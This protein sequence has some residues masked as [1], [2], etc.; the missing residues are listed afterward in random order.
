MEAVVAK[1]LTDDVGEP[2]EVLARNASTASEIARECAYAPV[3]GRRALRR[4][5]VKFETAAESKARADGSLKYTMLR[6]EDFE[7][8]SAFPPG[9]MYAI[10]RAHLELQRP[11]TEES[12]ES[13]GTDI[14]LVFEELPGWVYGD[15]NVSYR[16]EFTIT[17]Y[18]VF[19][20]PAIRSLNAIEYELSSGLAEKQALMGLTAAQFALGHFFTSVAFFLIESAIVVTL[21][22]T[23]ETQW[24]DVPYA[25][26]INP[27]MVLLSFFLYDVGQAL[28]PVL[29]TSV[30]PKGWVRTLLFL[31]ILVVAPSLFLGALYPVTVPDYLTASRRNQLFGGIFPHSA[32]VSVMMIM[33]LAQDY[34]DGAGWSLVTRRIMGNKVT[35]LEIW[36]LM[37]GSNVVMAFLTW[38]LPQILPWCTDNPRSPI[39]FLTM[40]YWRGAGETEADAT[41]LQRD[42]TRFEELP[43]DVRPIVLTRDLTK[44]IGTALVLDGVD[45]KVFEHKVTVLLGQNG[46]GKS[47]LMRILTGALG[48]PTSGGV[49][50]C[51]H[52]VYTSR[53]LVRRDVTLCEQSDVFFED[54]TC[55]ENAIYFAT[56]KDT[57]G[58]DVKQATVNM[59]EKL[60][61]KD[62]GPKMPGELASE[63]ARMLSLAIAI[64][65]KPKLLMLDEPCSDLTPNTRR[66]I[67]D[68]LQQIGR[69]RTVLLTSHDMDEAD[70]IADQIIMLAAGKVI[71]SGSTT[72]LKKACGV[73]YRVTLVKDPQLF[74]LKYALATIQSVVPSA[75]VYEDKQSAV[76]IRLRTLDHRGLPGLFEMLESSS[77]QLGVVDIGVTVATMKDVYTKINM[78]WTPEEKRPEAQEGDEVVGVLCRSASKPERTVARCFYALFIKRLTYVTRSWGIFIVSFL[79]PMVLPRLLLQ[80]GLWSKKSQ[81]EAHLFHLAETMEI[82]LAHY[83]PGYTV[84]L[85]ESKSMANL[86]RA[87]QVLVEAEGCN[88]RLV[89]DVNDMVV[90]DFAAYVRTYPMV[91]VPEPDRVRLMVDTRNW[92]PL[93]VLLNLAD[94]AMLRLLTRQPT[95]RIAAHISHLQ[96]VVTELPQLM[97]VPLHAFAYALAF[98]AFAAFPAAERLGGARDVQLMTGLTGSVYV[99][100][101]FAFDFLL[102][103]AFVGPWCLIN[104]G[105]DGILEGTCTLIF[106]TFVLSA[107]AII[108]MVYLISERALTEY[109]AMYSA[110]VWIYLPGF[111]PLFIDAID[112]RWW[113][114]MAAL[115]P[116]WALVS[117]IIKISN[118]AAAEKLCD[119]PWQ[120]PTRARR[121]DSA[122]A[123]RLSF[124]GRSIFPSGRGALAVGEEEHNPTTTR[125]QLCHR[126]AASTN[127]LDDVLADLLFLAAQG[128]IC[129]GLMSFITSGCFSWR[130]AICGKRII[131]CPPAAPPAAGDVK[132]TTAKPSDPEVEEEKKLATALCHKKDFKDHA[133]VAHNL[134]KTYGDCCALTDFNLALRHSECFG[135]LGVSGSGKTTALD[136]LAA[137]SDVTQGEAYTPT[138]SLLENTRKW[139]SQIGYCFQ[140]GCL[141]DKLN[142][143]EFLYLIARLRGVSPQ[144]VEATVNSVI[145][146]VDLKEHAGKPCGLYSGGTRRKLCVGVALLGLPP[147]LFLDEPYTGVDPMSRDRIGRALS[148]I[149]RTTRTAIMFA[150]HSIEECEFSCD[151]FAIMA[152]GGLTSM[153]TLQQLRDKHDRGYRLEFTLSHDADPD[154][155][156][157]LMEAVDRQ[158]VG[159]KLT[160]F[161]QN[162]LS[163]HL[164]ERMPWS[165][166][167]RKVVLLQKDFPLEHAIAGQNTLEQVFLSLA[168]AQKGRQRTK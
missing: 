38:Y 154:A 117:C 85:Q 165:E 11:R 73:G 61:L 27:V 127:L 105:I 153:G 166:L 86:S 168:K 164:V 157:R 10:E 121:P 80:D 143:Y 58:G 129:L 20:I 161:H 1:Y 113:K 163:Y 60:G 75:D 100:S 90:G 135:L 130:E 167:F 98:S 31:A 6:I 9:Y 101:H 52:S 25:Y 16:P 125:F 122:T 131:G 91:I 63:T 14:K 66:K 69:E 156:K 48:G 92:A 93:P 35:I 94:T 104:C 13:N 42:P 102:Y 109:G 79:V 136:L 2:V 70:V 134:S 126:A 132:S 65:S 82:R 142:A 76:T 159:V 26:G 97:W 149:K 17:L 115:Y 110:V 150:S 106:A 54:L 103:V 71:C 37:L 107:P 144:D 22:Y 8:L 152:R 41:P 43:P 30:L 64:A 140:K 111:I 162:V 59:L 138:A 19:M 62:V 88:V 147:L 158:F 53:E 145:S 128:L 33:F 68:L 95:A 3:R 139:Q 87:L 148:R 39:F 36:V 116:P 83:F 45:L 44:L 15:V 51:G 7:D 49:M 56:L 55:G 72:F 112:D 99:L 96:R 57:D 160:E 84:V 23:V 47:T 114:Y 119:R 124:A 77:K 123:A 155:A 141:L 24:N 146:I 29:V 108:G 89:P 40:Q 50:V 12:D 151:R 118:Q 34:K 67:W 78:N 21:M 120:R 74:N 32:L 18:A 5:C 28:T 81:D 46:T 4:M 137:L 133:L